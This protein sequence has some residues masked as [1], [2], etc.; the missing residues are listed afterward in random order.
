MYGLN[1]TLLQDYI[2]IPSL[3]GIQTVYLPLSKLMRYQVSYSG[4]F[5]FIYT[6]AFYK[7]FPKLKLLLN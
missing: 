4:K 5:A 3:A 6:L 7:L 1:L 2:K